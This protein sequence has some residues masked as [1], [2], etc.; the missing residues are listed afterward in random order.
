MLPPAHRMRRGSDFSLT[1]RQGTKVTRGRVV[2]YVH[3]GGT[4]A[5]LVGLIVGKVVGNS[6]VRHRVSRRLRGAMSSV[7][8]DLPAGCHVVLRA[9]AG[10]A[11]DP[12]LPGDAVRATHEAVLRSAARISTAPLEA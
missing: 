8:A 4:G 6:V 12:D 11:D 5:P 1:T 9:L 3:T 10:S 2:A 7:V